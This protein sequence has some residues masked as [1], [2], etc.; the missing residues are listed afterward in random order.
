MNARQ[1]PMQL[2]VLTIQKVI[3]H[4]IVIAVIYQVEAN[5]HIKNEEKRYNFFLKCSEELKARLLHWASSYYT[6]IN[7]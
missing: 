2:T 6:P 1:K 4:M 7:T 3:Q 5:Y